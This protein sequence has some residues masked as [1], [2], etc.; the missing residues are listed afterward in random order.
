[1]VGLA[2]AFGEVFDL[3]VLGGVLI[4]KVSILPFQV[5]DIARHHFLGSRDRLR[6]GCCCRRLSWL[7]VGCRHYRLWFNVSI[8]RCDICRGMPR[9]VATC[10]DKSHL[11]YVRDVPINRCRRNQEFFAERRLHSMR[12]EV[13]LGAIPLDA[14]GR[15]REPSR[16]VTVERFFD[17]KGIVAV[18][19]CRGMPRQV[20]VCRTLL[21]LVVVAHAVDDSAAAG[22][23][24][25]YP[26]ARALTL[27]CNFGAIFLG[28]KQRSCLRY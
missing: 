8:F 9:Q 11:I 4:T 22:P 20:G 18:V 10:R 14:P 6:H 21:S 13:A 5:R 1:M 27:G 7:V 26:Q 28:A 16:L 25:H 12:I 19:A 24:S 3:P 2:G 15:P 23:C 17:R